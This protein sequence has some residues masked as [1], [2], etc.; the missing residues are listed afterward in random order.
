MKLRELLSEDGAGANVGALWI[1]PSLTRSE[2]QLLVGAHKVHEDPNFHTSPEKQRMM[3]RLMK[4]GL[5]RA[6]HTPDIHFELTDQG[7]RV[8]VGARPARAAPPGEVSGP[9][10]TYLTKSQ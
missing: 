3:A 1:T 2:E 6:F 8:L 4:L 9:H 5:V 10:T 7:Q